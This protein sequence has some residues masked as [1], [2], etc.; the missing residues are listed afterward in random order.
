MGSQIISKIE[1]TTKVIS[2]FFEKDINIRFDNKELILS[3][4]GKDFCSVYIDYYFR[5]VILPVNINFNLTDA[6]A[7][8][9][10]M[11][12]LA[13][14]LLILSDADKKR[15]LLEIVKENYIEVYV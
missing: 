11:K 5:M 9:Y 6:T 1:K 3:Y 2:E 10:T 15:E 7:D 14:I 13:D 4:K 8:F 12:E